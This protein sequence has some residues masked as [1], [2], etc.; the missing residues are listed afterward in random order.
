MDS[1]ALYRRWIQCGWEDIAREIPE[2]IVVDF[3]PEVDQDKLGGR[4]PV[5]IWSDDPRFYP[6]TNTP[7]ERISSAQHHRL[8]G[9]SLQ[10]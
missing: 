9:S 1:K 8:M 7:Q 3:E 5:I 2:R 4:A 6:P 10:T